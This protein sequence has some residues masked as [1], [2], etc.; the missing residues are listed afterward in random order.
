MTATALLLA[1]LGATLLGVGLLVGGRAGK[2]LIAV[3]TAV[4][5]AG[6]VLAAV[7]LA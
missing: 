3:G 2:A 5:G 6:A 7:A 4:A 1:A